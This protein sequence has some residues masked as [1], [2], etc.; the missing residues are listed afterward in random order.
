MPAP[1]MTAAQAVTKYGSKYSIRK[2]GSMVM[3]KN[4]DGRT[5]QVKPSHKVYHR[6]SGKFG[7]YTTEADMRRRS[8]GS[9][10]KQVVGTGKYRHTSDFKGKA[11]KKATP[12]KATPAYVPKLKAI[13]KNH[14]A[15]T[16]GGT[17]VDV[18]TAN[19]ILKVRSALKKPE[20]RAKY[21]KMSMTAKANFA[22]KQTR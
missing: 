2:V 22:W 4:S 6:G 20:N 11:V 5:V 18:Q 12:S 7:L 8:S 3:L 16:I 21:D 14:S 10:G 9:K 15:K 13:V 17:L 1:I 19:V